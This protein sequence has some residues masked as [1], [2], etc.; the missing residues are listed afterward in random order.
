MII[1]NI[2]LQKEKKLLKMNIEIQRTQKKT[3]LKYIDEIADNALNTF[4]DSTY[5]F[6]YN[7]LL[8]VQSSIEK[9]DKNISMLNTLLDK[10]NSFSN[11][12]ENNFMTSYNEDYITY[13]EK[14]LDNTL[15]IQKILADLL[16]YIKFDFSSLN[17]KN[18][19]EIEN[20]PSDVSINTETQILPEK[21]SITAKDTNLDNDTV[22]QENTLIISHTRQKVILPYTKLE[23]EKI[24]KEK[25]NDYKNLQEIIDDKYTLPISYYKN[26]P[27]SRFK[28]AYSLAKFKA[29]ASVKQALDLGLELFFNSDLHPAIITACRTLD[30]LDIYLDYLESGEIE[31]FKCFSII[32]EIPPVIQQKKYDKH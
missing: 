10:L 1:S 18:E 8:K 4:K 19:T 14:I 23:L 16:E 32:F 24:L 31:K 20:I 30:E 6:I 3:I 9:S 17:T 15:E 27:L 13:H 26:I 29:H 21:H 28:E 2:D 5:D 11:E 12:D 7:Y 25:N 22:L